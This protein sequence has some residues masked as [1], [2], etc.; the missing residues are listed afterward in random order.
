MP[1]LTRQIVNRAEILPFYLIGIGS[2]CFLL[3]STNCRIRWH[4]P[5][6]ILSNLKYIGLIYLIFSDRQEG[7]TAILFV[8]FLLTFAEFFIIHDVS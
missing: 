8:A 1:A 4:F 5:G 3:W 7:K 6:Y 2:L